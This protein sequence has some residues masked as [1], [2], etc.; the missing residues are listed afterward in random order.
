[1]ED[2]LH[3]ADVFVVDYPT[4]SLAYLA[5]TD[6]PILFIDLGLRRLHPKAL[7]VVRQRCHYARIDVLEPEEGLN[8][9]AE[10]L[11]RECEDT[12]T[13]LFCLSPEGIDEVTSVAQAAQSM[14]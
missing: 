2:A 7:E 9:L 14:L 8:D 11:D 3:M 6:K 13:P 10:D 1:M 4:T 5:A 12:F